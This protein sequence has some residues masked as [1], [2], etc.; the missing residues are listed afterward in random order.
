MIQKWIYQKWLLR[1]LITLFYWSNFIQGQTPLDPCLYLQTCNA[2][3][4]DPRRC[5]WCNPYST[6]RSLPARSTKP[7]AD[8]C[9]N[10]AYQINQCIFTS[11]LTV[12]IVAV[13]G[14]VAA[15]CFSWLVYCYCCR[16]RNR[17]KYDIQIRN[18]ARMKRERR[19]RYYETKSQRRSYSDSI[20]Q[21]YDL[22][23]AGSTRIRTGSQRSWMSARGGSSFLSRMFSTRQR[24]QHDQSMTSTPGRRPLQISHLGLTTV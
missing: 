11:N 13:V 4:N 14:S 1:C 9:P 24:E 15:I 23:S 19:R 8:E 7:L 22:P 17:D 18:Y 5:Y 20:R 21:K 6:C 10:Q 3:I 2:C 12:I 16:D